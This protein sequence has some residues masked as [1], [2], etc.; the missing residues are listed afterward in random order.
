MENIRIS[1]ISSSADKKSAEDILEAAEL[2]GVEVVKLISTKKRS[3]LEIRG[4]DMIVPINRGGL[5]VE[6]KIKSGR[7]KFFKEDSG[8]LGAIVPLTPRNKKLIA[9]WLRKGSFRP[10]NKKTYEDIREFAIKNGINPNPQKAVNRFIGKG[11]KGQRKAKERNKLEL[12]ALKKEQELKEMKK[13]IAKIEEENQRLKAEQQKDTR[14]VRVEEDEHG[15]YN[16]KEIDGKEIERLMNKYRIGDR[17]AWYDFGLGD[18]KINGKKP[19][20]EYA[21]KYYDNLIAI[22]EKGDE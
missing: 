17:G 22:E 2:A 3:R 21:R 7:L 6:A 5:G 14:E 13:M 19:A 8:H 12:E 1:K 16:V 15:D 10:V 11:L 9:K 4:F 20:E 18:E